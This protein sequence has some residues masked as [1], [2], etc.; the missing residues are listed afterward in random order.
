MSAGVHRMARE[1]QLGAYALTGSERHVYELVSGGYPVKAYF[2]IEREPEADVPALTEADAVWIREHIERVLVAETGAA[3]AETTV[4]VASSASKF[5]QHLICELFGADGT[6]IVF[7]SPLDI[8]R[9]VLPVILSGIPEELRGAVD[10]G[11]YGNNQAFRMFL[12]SKAKAPERVLRLPGE[13]SL[14]DVEHLGAAREWVAKRD[15]ESPVP[16]VFRTLLQYQLPGTKVLVLSAPADAS[17]SRTRSVGTPAMRSE[18]ASDDPLLAWVQRYV[19]PTADGVIY[20]DPPVPGSAALT[21]HAIVR[22]RN[23]ECGL[24]RR[25]HKSNHI[26]WH[27]DLTER[28]VWQGCMDPGCLDTYRSALRDVRR[29]WPTT[30]PDQRLPLFRIGPARHD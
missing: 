12:S 5:S 4:L 30:F 3:R 21:T 2:D 23:H 19:D 14:A 28:V 25:L 29:F 20:F 26:R 7:A 22:T 27:V 24:A 11:V 13:G 10:P 6:P 1:R 17:R 9:L 18:G 16:V 15:G 8:K